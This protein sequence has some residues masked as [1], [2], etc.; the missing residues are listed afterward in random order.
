MFEGGVGGFLMPSLCHCHVAPVA[1]H[2]KNWTVFVLC[3]FCSSI[4]KIV[5]RTQDF[6]TQFCLFPF[7][8][9]F[10]PGLAS[11]ENCGKLKKLVEGQNWRNLFIQLKNIQSKAKR[12]VKVS[13]VKKV[14]KFNHDKGCYS[15]W[16][17]GSKSTLRTLN[18]T[19]GEIHQARLHS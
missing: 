7:Q 8:A 14:Q 9:T 6:K 5:P 11:Q 15:R 10:R 13:F 3:L 4:N 19:K 17:D 16:I 2:V 12:R 18:W 1:P